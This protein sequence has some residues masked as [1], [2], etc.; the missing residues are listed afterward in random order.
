MK[1]KK[2]NMKME[3]YLKKTKKIVNNLALADHPVIIEDLVSQG[4]TGLGFTGYNHV[5]C[6]ITEKESISWL[7]LQSKLLS[8]EKKCRATKCRHN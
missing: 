1:V 7:K 5:V 8:Y 6:Q 2:G 3:E 4:L